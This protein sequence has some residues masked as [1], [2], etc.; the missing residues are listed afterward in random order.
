MGLNQRSLALPMTVDGNSI[1]LG[2]TSDPN[3]APPGWY[4]IALVVGA[5]L[6]AS[7][8]GQLPRS[9]AAF[10]T[11]L[12]VSRSHQRRYPKRQYRS[13]TISTAV[14]TTMASRANAFRCAYHRATLIG[15]LTLPAT[16]W[17]M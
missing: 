9:L 10:G 8:L 16:A 4:I 14:I 11:G 6:T 2:V 5:I 3:M 12:A 13:R 1:G 15:A 7:L 17:P